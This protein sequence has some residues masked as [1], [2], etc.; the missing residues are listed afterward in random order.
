MLI[1]PQGRFAS[2][3]LGRSGMLSDRFDPLRKEIHHLRT[4]LDHVPQRSGLNGLSARLALTHG[5]IGLMDHLFGGCPAFK[6]LQQPARTPQVGRPTVD[7]DGEGATECLLLLQQVMP[8]PGSRF[9]LE[10]VEPIGFPP[11]PGPDAKFVQITPGLQVQHGLIA[12]SRGQNLLTE[13]V[14][15]REALIQ[16]ESA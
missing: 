15:C 11:L 5:Q 8:D 13:G 1:G 14:E 4:A 9:V 10:I 12:K 6:R 2:G 16:G 3:T 7:D